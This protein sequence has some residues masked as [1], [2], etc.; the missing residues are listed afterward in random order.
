MMDGFYQMSPI[1]M[2]KS[3][4]DRKSKLKTSLNDV[5]VLDVVLVAM[6]HSTVR[7]TFACAVQQCFA[8]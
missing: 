4:S 1:A 2:R 8:L 5:P 6:Q 7:S 3:A